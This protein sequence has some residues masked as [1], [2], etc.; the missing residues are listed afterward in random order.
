MYYRYMRNKWLSLKFAVVYLLASP[1]LFI[2]GVWILLA[3]N[4]LFN[5]HGN[6]YKESE[7]SQHGTARFL[8]ALVDYLGTGLIFLAYALVIFGVCLL[9]L[10]GIIKLIKI[11]KNYKN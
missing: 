2:L 5:N 9:L 3:G 7:F 8:K 11:C 6:G 1:T 10:H 4:D